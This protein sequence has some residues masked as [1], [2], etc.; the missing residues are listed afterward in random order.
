ML[1]IYY[2]ARQTLIL[3][4]Q[5][6]ET[7]MSLI[8]FLELSTI[9]INDMIDFKKDYPKCNTFWRHSEIRGVYISMVIV[10][11]ELNIGFQAKLGFV[12]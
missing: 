5:R 10:L 4:A 9:L 1:D 11:S 2:V 7:I 12:K 6:F 3:I 8:A